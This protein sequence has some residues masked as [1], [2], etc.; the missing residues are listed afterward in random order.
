MKKAIRILTVL[1]S[2]ILLAGLLISCEETGRSGTSNQKEEYNKLRKAFLD[3]VLYKEAKNYV[4]DT[5]DRELQLV[6]YE[7]SLE[8]G[9]L[10]MDDIDGFKDFDT[11]KET[12]IKFFKKADLSF[13]IRY[14]DD[15]ITDEEIKS[16]AEQI[17][18][19]QISGRMYSVAS[20]SKYCK[21]D[22]ETG[23]AKIVIVPEV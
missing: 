3:S 13:S 5:F 9:S 12:R 17:M 4:N 18:A 16:I 2:V 15:N 6:N 11:S 19:Y 10:T 21:L 20:S 7:M 23:K 22:A 8:P 14:A 1:L